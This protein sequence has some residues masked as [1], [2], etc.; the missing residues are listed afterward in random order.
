M[1]LRGITSGDRLGDH[2]RPLGVAV[3]VAQKPLRQCPSR[4]GQRRRPSFGKLL[5]CIRKLKHSR[6][7][8]A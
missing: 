8:R 2:I 1:A 6:S 3:L 5:R 4:A 7:A